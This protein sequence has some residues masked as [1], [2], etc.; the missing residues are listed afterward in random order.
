MEWRRPLAD[1]ATRKE[2][3]PFGPYAGLAERA[4]NSTHNEETAMYR[5][6]T[7]MM[8]LALGFGYQ[9]ANAAPPWEA[10]SVTVHFADL[11]LTQ[12]EGIAVLYRRLKRA[13]E[14]VCAHL[15]RSSDLGIQMRFKKCWQGALGAAVTKVDRPALAAYYRAQFK[16]RN[17][18]FQIAQN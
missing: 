2:L 3:P 10:P 15:D 5:F 6:A 4:P 12:S 14:T 18:A 8:I 13:A 11:D 7:T 17:A 9:L 1:S 16:G